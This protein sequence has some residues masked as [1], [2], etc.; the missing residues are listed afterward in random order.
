LERG[1]LGC[2]S[3]CECV[4]VDLG[5]RE[6]PEGE[7]DTA[8]QPLLDACDLEKRSPRIRAFRNRRTRR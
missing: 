7:A 8:G 4:R 1:R 6:M 3:G 5:Q 2:G